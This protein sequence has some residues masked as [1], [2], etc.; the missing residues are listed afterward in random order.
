[1]NIKGEAIAEKYRYLP[2]MTDSNIGNEQLYIPYVVRLTKE[3]VVNAGNFESSFPSNADLINVFTDTNT[4]Y[5]ALD[6]AINNDEKQA[7]TLQDSERDGIL[8]SNIEL[9]T[10]LIFKRKNTI[11]LV[12]DVYTIYE[13]RI[14]SIKTNKQTPT[15]VESVTVV[16]DIGVYQ[17]EIAR[18]KITCRGKRAN[19]RNS[20]IMVFGIDLLGEPKRS[21]VIPRRLVSPV[22]PLSVK[23]PPPYPGFGRYPYPL[24]QYPLQQYPL[25]QY[26]LQQ[27]YPQPQQYPLQQP[28]PYPGIAS[29]TGGKKNKQKRLTN[30]K[31]L[32]KHKLRRTRRY[33]K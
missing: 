3:D 27:S 4:L 12:G 19:L 6:Y 20:F 24:Q 22:I 25:Q 9:L 23:P 7:K 1:M 32:R 28:P 21:K 17:G 14:N 30:K 26:P 15:Q 33:K 5:K 11:R 29:T 8:R 16:I 2:N 10:E 31:K 18:Q 13:S